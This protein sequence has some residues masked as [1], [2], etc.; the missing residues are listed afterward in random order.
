[1]EFEREGDVKELKF[2]YESYLAKNTRKPQIILCVLEQERN[3]AAIK[4]FFSSQGIACQ[5]VLFR[6]AL[7]GNL[8]V[9]SNVLKQMNS[10]MGVNNYTLEIPK[11][12]SHNTMLIGID[13]THKQRRSI[14]GVC[15]TINPEMMQYNSQY[16]I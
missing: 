8:S 11:G 7:K 15:G 3:Y 6:N 12:I 1:M 13:V 14:V 16:I 2:R 5:V 4:N 9:A 10:K